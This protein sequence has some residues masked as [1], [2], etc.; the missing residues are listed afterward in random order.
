MSRLAITLSDRSFAR[1][2]QAFVMAASA[3]SLGRDVLLFAGGQSVLALTAETWVRLHGAEQDEALQRCGVADFTTLR[4]A[5]IDLGGTLMA[6]EAG[7]RM[8]GL[9]AAAL[10]EGV[11]VRGAVHFLECA[12]NGPFLGL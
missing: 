9:D 11:E 10:C 3:L 4:Q 12:G 1:A 8:T 2:H 6:C 5:V 7:M